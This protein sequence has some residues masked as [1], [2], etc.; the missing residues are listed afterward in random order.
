[1][2]G[3]VRMSSG[4]GA[5]LYERPSCGDVAGFEQYE[6]LLVTVW[7]AACVE[8]EGRV[9][10]SLFARVTDLH[11]ILWREF[12]LRT[13][14]EENPKQMDKSSAREYDL[15]LRSMNVR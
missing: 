14:Y 2:A 3:P 13:E 10:G 1:M 5:C 9:D 4:Y 8:K 12:A 6:Q 15:S 11:A 7:S